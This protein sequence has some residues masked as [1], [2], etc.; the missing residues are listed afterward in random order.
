MASSSTTLVVA[1]AEN[2]ETV[3]IVRLSHQVSF[4]ITSIVF[5]T[6]LL[7]LFLTSLFFGNLYRDMLRLRLH[8][9]EGIGLILARHGKS[10]R[11]TSSTTSSSG[12]RTMRILF[13]WTKDGRV[14]KNFTI[15]RM[16]LKLF[17]NTL[18]MISLVSYPSKNWPVPLQFH[19]FIAAVLYQRKLTFFSSNSKKLVFFG[20]KLRLWNSGIEAAPPNFLK[21]L[22]PKRSWPK[23]CKTTS[24]SSGK[25]W[26]FL[27]LSHPSFNKRGF[28]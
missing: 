9:Q 21:D 1:P 15:Y 20:T 8:L 4:N 24:T 3:S 12:T 10:L 22:T 28:T 18:V 2:I 27:K 19:R 16:M 7:L 25:L 5:F 14:S 23:Y 17:Y 26:N 6:S 11:M 13:Y